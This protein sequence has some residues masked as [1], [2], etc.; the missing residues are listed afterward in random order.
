MQEYLDF[1]QR[2]MFLV[3]GFFAILAMLV[4]T[5]FR[6]FTQAFSMV[7]TNE[8]IQLM[9]HNDIMILD[10]R[11]AKEFSAGHLVNSTHIP[12]T[13]I[14]KRAS[15]IEKY[16]DKDLLVYCKTDQRASIAA[17]Q[18]IKLGFKKISVLKGGINAWTSANLPVEK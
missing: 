6:R 17:R 14:A 3:I 4:F 12:T 10:V 15:E 13:A 16:K 8:A 1:A 2:N 7:N 11:E 9:N 5:E 18:L